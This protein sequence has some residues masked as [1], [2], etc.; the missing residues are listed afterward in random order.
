MHLGRTSVQDRNFEYVGLDFLFIKVLTSHS[1]TL[2]ETHCND[3]LI[4]IVKVVM[5]YRMWKTR[6]FLR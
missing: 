4:Q 1:R 3:V 2:N 6:I 5:L